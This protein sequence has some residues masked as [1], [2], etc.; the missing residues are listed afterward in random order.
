MSEM[1]LHRAEVAAGALEQLDAARVPECMRVNGVH[2]DPLA[3]ILDDLPDA[4]TRHSS[5]LLLAAV[6][7][8]L[9]WNSGGQ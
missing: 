3:E 5:D 7:L 8:V 1:L 6:P 2:A 9:H 4:L